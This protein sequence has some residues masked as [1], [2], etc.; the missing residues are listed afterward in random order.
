MGIVHLG[1]VILSRGTI[2]C[3]KH[4]QYLLRNQSLLVRALCVLCGFITF[5]NSIYIINYNK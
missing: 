2:S 3:L 1:D 5:A 4:R